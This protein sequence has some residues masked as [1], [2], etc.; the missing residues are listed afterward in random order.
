[1]TL[2]EWQTTVR[3]WIGGHGGYF[4]PQANLLRLVEEVGELS[5]AINTAHGP[6]RKKLGDA[7]VAR[8]E[9]IGDCLFVL[10]CLADQLGL[11]LEAVAT[12]TMQKMAAR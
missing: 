7:A 4:P 9:E 6:K 11:D 5:R 12:A 8:E 10:A 3:S 1:M 2:E